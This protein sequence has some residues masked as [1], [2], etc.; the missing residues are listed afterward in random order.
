MKKPQSTV[1]GAALMCLR[2]ISGFTFIVVAMLNPRE[3]ARSIVLDGVEPGSLDGATANLV[4]AIVLGAYALAL[5]LYLLLALFVFLG[6]NWARIVAMSFATISI[7]VSFVRYWNNGVEITLRTTLL[8][9]ALDILILLALSS[10]TARVYARRPRAQPAGTAGFAGA[11]DAAGTAAAGSGAGAV[12]QPGS[13][14]HTQG[15]TRRRTRDTRQ[16]AAGTRVRGS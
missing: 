1:Y 14:P 13:D 11:A 4:L 6:H 10:T 15:Q 2:T 16:A 12:R 3:F 5:A 7:I 9:L 8:S